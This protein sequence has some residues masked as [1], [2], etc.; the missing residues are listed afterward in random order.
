[1]AGLVGLLVC[2]SSPQAAAGDAGSTHATYTLHD[3]QA[4]L[5]AGLI[6]LQGTN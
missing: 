2:A 1:M 6:V 4:R 5:L 3:H